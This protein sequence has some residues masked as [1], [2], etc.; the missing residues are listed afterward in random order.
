[1]ALAR[2]APCRAHKAKTPFQTEEGSKIA[3]YKYAPNDGG[4]MGNIG[5]KR[6]NILNINQLGVTYPQLSRYLKTAT[7]NRIIQLPAQFPFGYIPK[8]ANNK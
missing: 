3:I 1:M 2:H 5:H 8:I 6:K 4:Y 7:G